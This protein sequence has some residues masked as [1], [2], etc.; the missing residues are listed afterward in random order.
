MG[1]I[2]FD[3]KIGGSVHLALGRAY[4]VADNGNRSDIHWDLVLIQDERR[5][6]GELWLDGELIRKNGLFVVDDLKGLNPEVLG[7]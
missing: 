3:E 4:E 6:G 7:G 1:D 5:G 2:L